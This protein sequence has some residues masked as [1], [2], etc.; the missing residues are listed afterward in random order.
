MFVRLFLRI[1]IYKSSIK[2]F[3]LAAAEYEFCDGELSAVAA[4]AL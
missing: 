4:H 2:N 1:A 3:S